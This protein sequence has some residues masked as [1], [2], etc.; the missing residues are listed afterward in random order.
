MI[1]LRANLNKKYFIKNYLSIFI[2]NPFGHI[3][4]FSHRRN[5]NMLIFS[6]LLFLCEAK[7]L[8]NNQHIV[9]INRIKV[10]EI[11]LFCKN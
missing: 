9:K 3:F 8:A 2:I 6:Y 7:N 11:N 4:D 5:D 1:R 10:L